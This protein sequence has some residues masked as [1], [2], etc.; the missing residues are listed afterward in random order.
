[1]SV[2][3]EQ[4]A[5]ADLEE[6]AWRNL[7]RLGGRGARI[8]ASDEEAPLHAGSVTDRRRWGLFDGNEQIPLALVV[9]PQLRDLHA[10][11]QSKGVQPPLAFK[12]R[13]EAQRLARLDL[14]LSLDDL[15]IGPHVAGNQD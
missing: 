15:R 3:A 9:V 14:E 5:A 2:L 4:I 10:P 12:F 1:R 7:Q 8:L 13:R 6:S 11:K